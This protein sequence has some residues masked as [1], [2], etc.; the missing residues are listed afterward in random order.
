MDS[1]NPA[2]SQS[3]EVTRGGVCPA[4]AVVIVLV[5]LAA[6]VIAIEVVNKYRKRNRRCGQS[7]A[8]MTA[9]KPAA[10][11]VFAGAAHTLSVLAPSP[12]C[13]NGRPPLVV[14]GF[15]LAYETKDSLKSY[16]GKLNVTRPFL[17]TKKNIGMLE[18][19]LSRDCAHR[20]GW[21][22]ASTSWVCPDRSDEEYEANFQHLL[23]GDN[24]L[25]PPKPLLLL[26]SGPPD[27]SLELEAY[28]DRESFTERVV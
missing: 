12:T 7:C 25:N 6:V 5:M 10:R 18:N 8:G 24:D 14:D 17:A 27:P 26:S 13:A 11:Q 15:F 3:S 16:C 21:Y 20:A 1:S 28:I 4:T 19:Y 2:K 22:I 23:S 9:G